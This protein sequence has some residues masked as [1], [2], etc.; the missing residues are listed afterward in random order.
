MLRCKKCGFIGEYRDF[1]TEF[2]EV[3]ETEGG[4]SVTLHCPKCDSE[5]LEDLNEMV[6]A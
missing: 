3:L 6:P 1:K 4:I 2:G 5:D